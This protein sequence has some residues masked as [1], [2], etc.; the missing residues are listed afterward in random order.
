L[1]TVAE[2]T[3][4]VGKTSPVNFDATVELHVNLNVDPRHADQNIRDNLVLPAGT[5]KT[6]RV[7]VF[8]DETV[9]GADVQG[10]EDIT[11]LL[12]KGTFTF[13]ILIATPATMAKIR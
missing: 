7:A 9:E 13:D 12:E 10:I 4:L 6:V 3:E 2:A 5:G 8:A 11:K 1:Y